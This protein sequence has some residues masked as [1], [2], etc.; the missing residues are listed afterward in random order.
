VSSRAVKTAARRRRAR[1]WCRGCGVRG[2]RVPWSTSDDWCAACAAMGGGLRAAGAGARSFRAGARTFRDRAASRLLGLAGVLPGAGQ[3]PAFRVAQRTVWARGRPVGS[4]SLG[5]S[6]RPWAHVDV[7]L[8]RRQA[9]ER[10]PTVFI[11]QEDP[12]SC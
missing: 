11:H 5:S 4:D 12:P 9:A 3:L 7:D 10:W 1:R 6:S 8:L 2:A